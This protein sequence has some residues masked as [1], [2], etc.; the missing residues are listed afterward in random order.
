MVLGFVRFYRFLDGVV[1]IAAAEGNKNSE[2]GSR[3]RCSLGGGGV[4]ARQGKEEGTK[5]RIE[6]V[7]N[8]RLFLTFMTTEDSN[9]PEERRGKGVCWKI[10]DGA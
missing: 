4:T 8:N 7:R 5:N 3:T 10:A 6:N 1:R 9:D 2:M